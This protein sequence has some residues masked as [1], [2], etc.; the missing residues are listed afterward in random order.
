MP[1]ES[2]LTANKKRS[3]GTPL[4]EFNVPDGEQSEIED[5]L[6]LRRQQF[7][8]MKAKKEKQPITES[9][10]KRIE[11]LCGMLS[12]TREATINDNKFVLKL[13]KAKETAYIST[14]IYKPDFVYTIERDIYFKQITL[15]KSLISIN[16]V[17]INLFLSND[18]NDIAV[19]IAFVQ[20]LHDYVVDYLFD[21][22]IKLNNQAKEQCGIR[23]KEQAEDLVEDLKK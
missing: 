9:A 17:D 21:E 18:E 23:T 2:D 22:Y 10:K 20:E 11:M 5:N 12:L 15:A 1:Y 7:A 13:L 3:V 16:D 4:R 8:Q 14:E 19:N 6:D